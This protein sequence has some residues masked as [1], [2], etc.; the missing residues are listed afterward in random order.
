MRAKLGIVAGGGPLPGRLVAACRADGRAVFVLALAG[1]ADERMLPS[2]PDARIRIDRA[3]RGIALLREAGVAEVVFAGKVRRPALHELRP[4][5]W[6]AKFLARIGRAYFGED[7]LASALAREIEKEGFSVVGPETVI[8][9]L[10]AGESLLGAVVPDPQAQSDVAR[11]VEVARAIGG[12]DIGQSAIVQQGVVLGVEAAEGTDALI[13][14][15]GGIRFDGPGGVLVKVSKPGQERRIDL[16][17][18]GPATVA[19]A[20]AAGLRGIAIEAGRALVVEREATVRAADEAGIFL[21][22]VGP[23]AAA[24]EKCGPAPSSS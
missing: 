15:C 3:G 9:D 6:T 24:D 13:E 19:A 7:S 4:D 21:I 23:Q 8:E 14:R 2:P 16:P 17:V 12:L 18:I 11:G 10:I 5:G 1:Q 20:A 22:G